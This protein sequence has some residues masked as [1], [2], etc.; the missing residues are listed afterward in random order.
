MFGEPCVAQGVPPL[1]KTVVRDV[2]NLWRMSGCLLAEMEA[3]ETP[4]EI[5]DRLIVPRQAMDNSWQR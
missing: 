1:V 4:L 2:K 5:V 3:R